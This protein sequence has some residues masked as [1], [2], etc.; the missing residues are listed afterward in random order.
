[1]SE[2][3]TNCRNVAI[4]GPHLS[5]KTTLLESI[6]SVTGATTRKGTAKDGN[7]VGDSCAEARE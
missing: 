4:V 1:M 2:T 6:L 3:V 5:G 7:R